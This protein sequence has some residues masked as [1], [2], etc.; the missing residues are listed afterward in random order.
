[1]LSFN[2]I[3]LSYVIILMIGIGFVNQTEAQKLQG[4][5]TNTDKSL[6]ELS[7]LK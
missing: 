6:I 2:P 1:M 3:R 5:D 4:W 7:E